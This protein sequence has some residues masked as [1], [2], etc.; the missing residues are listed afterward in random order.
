MKSAD[1]N[2]RAYVDLNKENKKED[3]KFEV[4]DHV[5]IS[6][7]KSIFAK[8]YTAKWSEEVFAIK[9]KNCSVD[10]Y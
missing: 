7:Y 4:G 10:T 1:V 6:K 2:L 3:P 8:S 5:R 9:K